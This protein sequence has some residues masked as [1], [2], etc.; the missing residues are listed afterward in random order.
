MKRSYQIGLALLITMIL[1]IITANV[2]LAA[3]YNGEIFK[4]KQPDNTYV[5]VKVFGDEY[6]QRAESLD[7]YT[8]CYDSAGWICYAVM[9]NN[10]SDF[11]STGIIY[12]GSKNPNVILKNGKKLE[13]GIKLAKKQIVD[14]VQKTRQLLIPG[15]GAVDGISSMAAPAAAPVTGNILGLALLINFPDQTSGISKTAIDN[16]LNQ[17]GYT[18][19]S[20]NGSVKDYYYSVSG[21]Q[22]TYTNYVS[23][24]YTAQHPKSY[25]TD[26]GIPYAQRAME[27]V[28]EAIQWLDSQGY[29]FATL[30]KDSG[31]NV[32]AINCYYAGEPD[33]AWGTGLWP[34]QGWVNPKY[35]VDGVYCYKYQM[36]N[37]GSSLSI[38][39]TVHE[40]GHMVCS[41]PDLYDYDGDSAGA[42]RYCVM[43]YCDSKNPQVPNPHYRST[44]G[45][46]GF[47]RLNDYASG[48][49]ITVNAGSLGAY[50][51]EGPNSN[52]FFLVENLR[53][54]G[55]WAAVPDEGL[56][57]WHVDTNGNNSWNQMTAA[58]HFLVSVEQA[59]G[60][61][62]L[63]YNR[64]SGDT[65][66]LFHSGWKIK[67]DNITTP[68]SKWWNGSASGLTIN[69]VSAIGNSMTFTVG[70]GTPAT[71][72]PTP[73][74]P[75]ASNPVT[76]YKFDET[77][78]TTAYD[79]SGNGRNATLVNGPTW[80]VGRL[81]NAVNLDGS[82]DYVS[83][84]SGIVSSLNDFTIATWVKLDTLSTWSRIFDIGTGTSVYMFLIPQ[85]G[86]GVRYAITTGGSG[87]EQRINASSALATGV[88]KHVTVTLSGSTGILYVDG[89]EVG[90]NSSMTL[91]PSSLGNTNLNYIGRSQYADPYL[92]GQVDD[93][94][95]YNRALSASE[96]QSLA[97][98]GGSTPTPTPTATPTP[99]PASTVTPTPTPAATPTPTPVFS[100]NFDDGNN[101]GWS[102]HEGTW[103]VSSGQY[104][105][106]ST[107]VEGKTTVTGSNYS[108]FTYEVDLTPTSTYSTGIMFRASNVGSGTYNWQGYCANIRNSDN[109]VKL[110]KII[111]AAWTEI[112]TAA[113]TI[114]LNT[115]YK[116]KV[117]TSGSSIKVYLDGVLK[118]DTTD[119]TYTSGLI[120]LRTSSASARYDNVKLW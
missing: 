101:N 92:D 37:I 99:T 53:K 94:R 2:V 114:S 70:T 98:G 34:H 76:W 66:D 57:V 63:E 72:T 17:T 84:P 7:G 35:Y 73:T 3:P 81:G 62:D 50:R 110:G 95:I 65:N 32:L 44:A 33:S 10:G 85:S 80:V 112:G 39:T 18:G 64:N 51:W 96:I 36:S 4:F 89:V 15:S 103:G 26:P 14:K 93:F 54:T 21:G 56:M 67:F 108:N 115:T 106:S 87:A 6:Y 25:Y 120:G 24:F 117:V 49:V 102:V 16:M 27:L 77:S 116:L 9:N 40:N 22:L 71:P 19:Y 42:G 5:E 45:W 38:G 88:W 91:K 8:L 100:D 30:S 109:T 20:N 12:R 29:N 48:S 78:G 90:R 107:D 28:K 23:N 11:V 118:I 75:P 83:M 119:A 55:R 46:T 59:D 104:V 58:N 86:S 47:T 43:S 105:C 113:A 41:W 1:L 79:S 97:N 68:S 31:N 52:E 111:S 61:Y 74:A 69:N 13:K 82:N 60:L